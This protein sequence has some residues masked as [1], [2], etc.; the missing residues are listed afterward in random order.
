MKPFA[1]LRAADVETAVAAVD[2]DPQARFLAGGSNL[3][4]LWKSGVEQP[5]LLVDISRLPGLDTIDDRGNTLRIGALVRNADVADDVRVRRGWPL[6]AQALLS[7]A[8]P[9]L[10]NAATTG[11]NLLQRTRC[12]YFTDVSMPC[13]KRLP[14]SG[15]AA[16]DGGHQRIHAILGAS[17]AC[18]ATHPSDMAVALA[19]LDAVVE[20]RG[21]RGQ[22][23]IPIADFHTLPGT[24]P[25]RDTR[26]EHGELVT[27]VAVPTSSFG[28]H[29]AY[30]KVRERSSYA[31]ATVSVAAAMDLDGGVIRRAGIALGGVAHKPWRVPAADALLIG[32]VPGEKVFARAADAVLEGA[33]PLPG[34]AFKLPL[35]R[36][37]IARALALAQQGEPTFSVSN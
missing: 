30:L 17:A 18:I 14:G 35:A 3:L 36:R 20:V 22:R 37:A 8:S 15:C 23:S 33:A 4:D 9:Q 13:N 32:Q 34:N 31:F 28:A 19:A 29:V 21:L 16:L 7:G 1:Y 12:Y 5:S 2:A 11:G 27:S 26:L 24:R 25:E 6:L 10:R